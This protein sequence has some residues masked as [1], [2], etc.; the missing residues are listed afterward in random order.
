VSNAAD[1][2]KDGRCPLQRARH[3]ASA[4]ACDRL[5]KPVATSACTLVVRT[6]R[7]PLKFKRSFQI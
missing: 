7:K 2:F 3:D 5:A 6:A 4:S 1:W